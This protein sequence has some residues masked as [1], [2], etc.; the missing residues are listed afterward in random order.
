M[1]SAMA[2][3]TLT[4]PANSGGQLCLYVNYSRRLNSNYPTEQNK[5]AAVAW[6]ETWVMHKIK[7]EIAKLCSLGKKKAQFEQKQ[8]QTHSLLNR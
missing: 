6:S 2:P 5:M 3:Q 4:Q 7:S 1:I 8:E